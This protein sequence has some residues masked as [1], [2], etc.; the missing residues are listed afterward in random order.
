MCETNELTLIVL[1]KKPSSLWYHEVISHHAFF[2]LFGTLYR[3][4]HTTSERDCEPCTGERL[5][6]STA[7]GFAT[8][9]SPWWTT[10]RFISTL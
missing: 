3:Y 10:H 8:P 2:L 1:T 4:Y 9:P 5:P 7:C 6:N